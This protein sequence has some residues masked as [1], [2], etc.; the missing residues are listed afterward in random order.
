MG[1]PGGSH[2]SQR[3]IWGKHEKTLSETTRAGTLIFGMQKMFMCGWGRGRVL[4]C[5]QRLY[6]GRDQLDCPPPN[7]LNYYLPL[8]KTGAHSTG[9]KFRATM[10][11]LSYILFIQIMNKQNKTK[12]NCC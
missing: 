11:L 5:A 8:N 1:P 7:G 4:L 6:Y 3:P 12:Q 2:V 9:E 10:A